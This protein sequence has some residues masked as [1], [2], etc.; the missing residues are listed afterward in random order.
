MILK[1]LIDVQVKSLVEFEKFTIKELEEYNGRDG[2]RIY[3]AIED[4]VYDLSKSRLWYGGDHMRRH[5]G[6]KE[7]TEELKKAPHCGPFIRFGYKTN[8]F[9]MIQIV[10]I[11]H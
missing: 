11:V 7:L 1:N 4:N 2:K 10:K 6:G 8:V 5:R 9:L 3:V